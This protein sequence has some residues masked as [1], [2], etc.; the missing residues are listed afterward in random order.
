M[1]EILFRG[2]R[3]DNGEWVYGFY[4]FSEKTQKTYIIMSTPP[5]DFA[6]FIFEEV[7]PETVEQYTGLTD[8][9]G[10]KIFKGDIIREFSENENG[11]YDYE[12]FDVGRVFW[13]QETARFLKTSKLF[14]NNCPEI[15]GFREYEVIG[16]IHENPELPEQEG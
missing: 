5:E 7:I 8:K 16:N 2:K 1:S 12:H 4:A 15:T 14:P 9:N 13:Y 11:E 6:T 10:K 3:V